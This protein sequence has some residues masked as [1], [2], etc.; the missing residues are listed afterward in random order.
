MSQPLVPS[1]IKSIRLPQALIE[2][3]EAYRAEKNFRSWT[4]ALVHLASIGLVQ[5]GREPIELRP[6]GDFSRARKKE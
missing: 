6:W 1:I 4:F 3:I 2:E 5:Q